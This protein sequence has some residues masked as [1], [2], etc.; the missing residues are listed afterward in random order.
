VLENTPFLYFSFPH[1]KPNTLA[2]QP[3]FSFSPAICDLSRTV[4]SPQAVRGSIDFH[5]KLLSSWLR[6]KVRAIGYAELTQHAS[7][8]LFNMRNFIEDE[9]R[10]R[11]NEP[12]FVS[13]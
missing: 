10:K 6:S 3:F 1:A 9:F 2:P 11:E 4:G 5:S 8:G 12:M 13:R 7:T